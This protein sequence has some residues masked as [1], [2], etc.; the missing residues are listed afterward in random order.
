M[1]RGSE[2]KK[3]RARIALL[4]EENADLHGTNGELRARQQEHDREFADMEAALAQSRVAERAPIRGTDEEQVY[5][6]SRN[7]KNFHRPGCK[8]ASFIIGSASLI[9]FASHREAVEAGYK[10]CKTCRA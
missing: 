1:S 7:R 4:E 8:W 3:L 5:Y 10:P 9:V 6:A 2:I